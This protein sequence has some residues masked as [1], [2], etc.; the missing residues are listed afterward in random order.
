M[1][2][3]VILPAYN[4]EAYLA[5]CLDS[6][7]NQTFQD[8]CILAINDASIDNTSKILESYAKIDPR[9]RVYHFTQNQGE[10]SAGKLAKDI[11]NY[12]NVEYVAR[13]DAD[14]ICAPHRFEKQIQYLENHPEID[15]LGSNAVLFNHEQT[16]KSPAISDLP[17][18]DKDIKAHFSLARG[19]MINPSVMW[20][21]SSIKELGLNY[22]QTSTAPDF[23]MWIQCALNGKT[24]AN[25][26]EPL[27]FYRVHSEQESQKRA[28][29]SEAVQYSMEL[30]I[31][32]LFPE[33]QSQEVS[34]LSRILHEKSIRL[35]TE[36][37]EIAFSAYDKVRANH[38]PSRFGED[39]E[40]MFSILDK[41]TQFLKNVFYENIA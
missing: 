3:A 41:H 5:E 28:K 14:D 2:L 10:P 9:L 19:H 32:H 11:L 31:H 6:L 37:F 12:M 38:G 23:H 40:T 4:A 1:K 20:R 25:L 35:T 17:L 33:L 18:L 24:F 29:L 30:W 26:P 22:A 16:D 27:L 36:E 15:I 13:M 7:L 8:F 39:R 21:H 34:L